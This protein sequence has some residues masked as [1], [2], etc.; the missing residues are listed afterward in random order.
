MPGA[1]RARQSVVVEAP[2]PCRRSGSPGVQLGKQ[3]SALEAGER[4]SLGGPSLQIGGGVSFHSQQQMEGK[5]TLPHH[6]L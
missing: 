3:R 2:W 1:L 6:P 5:D 4:L